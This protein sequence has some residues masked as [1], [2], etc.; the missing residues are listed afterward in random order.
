MAETQDRLYPAPV[1]AN[2]K[3]WCSPERIRIGG[4]NLR[5]RPWILNLIVQW[6][7]QTIPVSCGIIPFEAGIGAAGK[8]EHILGHIGAV[9]FH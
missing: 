9:V 7:K 2:S 3:D 5:A 1:S 4:N 6:H 8:T